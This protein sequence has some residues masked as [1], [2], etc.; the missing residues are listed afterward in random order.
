MHVSGIDSPS[1]QCNYKQLLIHS[2]TAAG[3]QLPVL[4]F[5]LGIC[6]TNTLSGRHLSVEQRRQPPPFKLS[7]DLSMAERYL[8]DGTITFHMDEQA[9]CYKQDETKNILTSI[10]RNLQDAYPNTFIKIIPT[11]VVFQEDSTRGLQPKSVLTREAFTLPDTSF[12]ECWLPRN[13]EPLSNNPNATYHP[14]RLPVLKIW[15]DKLAYKYHNTS[16]HLF[17]VNK[18]QRL[19]CALEAHD[20]YAKP[21]MFVAMFSKFFGLNYPERD[22]ALYRMY[23]QVHTEALLRI[24]TNFNASQ[25]Y[26]FSPQPEGLPLDNKVFYPFNHNTLEYLNDITTGATTSEPMN[27]PASLMGNLPHVEALWTAGIKLKDNEA[28]TNNRVEVGNSIKWVNDVCTPSD[29]DSKHVKNIVRNGSLGGGG[30]YYDFSASRYFMADSEMLVDI[31]AFEKQKAII[32]TNSPADGANLPSEPKA[33]TTRPVYASSAAPRNAAPVEK[34]IKTLVLEE[35][36]AK[37]EKEI[38]EEDA[39]KAKA[40][41]DDNMGLLLL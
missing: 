3:A 15:E 16:A 22:N 38:A 9:F 10:A 33:L 28:I 29:H 30:A 4:Y 25:Y 5:S 2:S 36:L 8:F 1:S 13:R 39:A 41:E 34:H 12:D 32:A 35:M 20:N 17:R 19:I 6:L 24:D 31:L 11:I 37:A 18:I 40:E 14:L 26:S 23:V 21:K 7:Q 27:F